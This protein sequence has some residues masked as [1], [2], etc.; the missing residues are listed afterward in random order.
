MLLF[1]EFIKFRIFDIH[2]MFFRF[3]KM[4]EIL[5]VHLKGKGKIKSYCDHNSETI[6]SEF[7]L[8]KNTRLFVC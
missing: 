6:R 7:S 2:F 3:I 1:I 5:F 8:I 4:M